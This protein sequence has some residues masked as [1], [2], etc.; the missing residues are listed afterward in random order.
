MDKA[1]L[2]H[3]N[4]SMAEAFHQ[5][6]A[7]HII[8]HALLCAIARLPIR[9]QRPTDTQRILLIR[10]D[11]L[12]D[13]LLITPAVHALR[14]ALPEAEIHAL[15]GPWSAKILAAYPEF[16]KVFTLPYPGFSR[17]TPNANL[18]SPYFLALRTARNLRLIGYDSV[19]ILRPDHWWG[20]LLAFLAGIPQRI[21]YDLADVSPFLTDALE[22]KRE[23]A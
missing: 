7:K 5:R 2:A 19:L 9:Q 15:V 21:G 16:D 17:S 13:V 22:P 23:H 14:T 20:A 4:S 3:R 1:A 12:G 11:H 10:P 18:H 8:R 6:P